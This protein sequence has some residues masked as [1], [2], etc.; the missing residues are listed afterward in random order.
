M[1]C[2]LIKI[3]KPGGLLHVA[4]HLLSLRRDNKSMYYSLSMHPPHTHIALMIYLCYS[5]FQGLAMDGGFSRDF[6]DT[7]HSGSLPSPGPV[8]L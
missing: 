5:P 1:S 7:S 2:A 3:R 6:Q 8:A 4:A